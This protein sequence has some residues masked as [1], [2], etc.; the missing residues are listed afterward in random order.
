MVAADIE[1]EVVTMWAQDLMS[2]DFWVGHDIL[3]YK[4]LKHGYWFLDEHDQRFW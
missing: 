4:G 1:D 2:E 3:P